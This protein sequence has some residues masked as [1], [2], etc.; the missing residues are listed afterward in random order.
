M[1]QTVECLRCKEVMEEVLIVDTSQAAFLRQRSLAGEPQKRLL[2][3]LKVDGDQLIPVT[4]L[5]CPKCGSLESYANGSPN[6]F[7]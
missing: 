4:T 7:A 2:G 1:S 5:R 6:G 3:G